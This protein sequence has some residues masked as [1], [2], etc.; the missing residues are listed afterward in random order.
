MFQ[1]VSDK[2]QVDNDK[3]AFAKVMNS[4][5]SHDSVFVGDLEAIVCG[6]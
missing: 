2:R 6:S 3:R 5:V 4:M 1:Y